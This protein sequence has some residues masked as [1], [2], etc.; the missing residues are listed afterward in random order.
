MKF[1]PL[2]YSYPSKR[3][4]IYGKRHGGN[5]AAVAQAGLEIL[6]S[7]NAIDT[8][9]AAAACLTVVN[10]LQWDRRRSVC[11]GMVGW[12]AVWPQFKQAGSKAFR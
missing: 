9:V 11:S 5:L 12:E 10:L 4:V 7:G 2:V 3:H 8:A 1:D 6:K